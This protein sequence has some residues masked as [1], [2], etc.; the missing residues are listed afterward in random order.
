[1]ASSGSRYDHLLLN[2]GRFY[3]YKI[4]NYTL[5]ESEFCE[6]LRFDTRN[7]DPMFPPKIKLFYGCFFFF[8]RGGGKGRDFDSGKTQLFL[9]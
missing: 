6:E 5:A 2:Y 8:L 3:E 7:E 4:K 1:M 9:K